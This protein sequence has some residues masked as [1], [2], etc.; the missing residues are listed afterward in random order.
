M[1]LTFILEYTQGN[2]VEAGTITN[3]TVYGGANDDRNERGEYL[4]LSKNDK[5]GTRTY[6]SVPN[7]L[8]LSR[9]EW[10]I[11]SAADGWHQ[12]TLLS[13]KIWSSGQTY[14]VGDIIYYDTTGLFY[15]CISGH[16]NVAPDSGSGSSNWTAIADFTAIQ[17]GFTNIEVTDFSFNVESRIALAAVDKLDENIGDD[18][19]AKVDPTEAVDILNMRAGIEAYRSKAVQEEFSDVEEIVRAIEE[20]I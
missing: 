15:R 9:V 6:L 12:A 4:L 8:P 7:T 14:I 3:D 19:M 1:A 2:T 5:N 17:T 16:T 11:T 20:T 13:A 10:D 18:F